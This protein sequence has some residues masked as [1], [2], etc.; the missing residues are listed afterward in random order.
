MVTVAIQ[1]THRE[2]VHVIALK[3]MT[4]FFAQNCLEFGKE[5]S[6]QI[7]IQVVDISYINDNQFTLAR[8]EKSINCTYLMSNYLIYVYL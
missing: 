5:L 4:Y 8:F 6:S 1:I 7:A 3:I 2:S